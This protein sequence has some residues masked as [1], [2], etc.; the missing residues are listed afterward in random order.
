MGKMVEIVQKMEVD[1]N[2][3]NTGT[4]WASQKAKDRLDARGKG[5]YHYEYRDLHQSCEI[6]NAKLLSIGFPVTYALPE[7]SSQ[8]T[9]D[10]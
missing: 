10:F 3:V 5:S 6:Q 4:A 2:I 8:V 7:L 1:A 9:S